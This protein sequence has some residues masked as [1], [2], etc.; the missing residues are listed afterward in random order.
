[1]LT[2]LVSGAQVIRAYAAEDRFMNDIQKRIDDN[3]RPF[4]YLWV[5]NRWLAVRVDFIGATIALS[6]SVAVLLSLW[7]G[8]G[9]A[10]GAAGLSISYS[11]SFSEAILVWI[12]ILSCW[13][14]GGCLGWD[15]LH[16]TRTHLEI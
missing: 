1:M 13:L 10:P 4:Y 7:L 9:I 2:V 14:D 5:S 16:T 12:V 6:A 15:W 11:L 3:H 8:L